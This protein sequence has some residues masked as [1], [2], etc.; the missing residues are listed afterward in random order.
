MKP[1]DF[2]K[3]K[4]MGSVLQKSEAETVAQNIMKILKRTGDEFRDLSFDEYTYERLKDGGYSDAEV[5]YFDA[6]IKFCKSA[7]T[8]KCFS[9]FWNF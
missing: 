2:A 8:A 9:K 1:S 7:D 3:I 6:V 4:P 5:P